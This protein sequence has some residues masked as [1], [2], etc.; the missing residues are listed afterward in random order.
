MRKRTGRYL[1]GCLLCWLLLF[2]L[3]WHLRAQVTIQNPDLLGQRLDRIEISGNRITEEE[4]ILREM[5]SR[6]GRIVTAEMLQ[7]DRLRVTSLD[8][9]SRVEFKLI[10]QDGEIVLQVIVTEEWYIF[11]T[12]FWDLTTDE[13]PKIIYGF[14]YVQKNLRGRAETLRVRLWGGADRGFKF[15]HRN[16]WVKGTPNFT[17]S[18]N[19]YQITRKSENLELKDQHLEARHTGIRLTFGRRW[20]REIST[21]IGSHFRIVS[22]GDPRQLA[23]DGNLD[24]ILEITASA[25]YDNRDLQ[26]FPKKGAYLY[27]W[28]T[29]GWL[30][31]SPL[32]YERFIFDVRRYF[33]CCA[34]FSICSRMTWMPA[35]GA[36]PPYDWIVVTNTEPI[37][38]AR[39][40]DEGKSFFMTSLEMRFELFKLH[41]FTW[42]GAPV[43]KQ[44]VRNLRYGL[45][46]ECFV[47]SGDAY[48]ARY[49]V[50]IGSLM[51]G[52]GV[53]LL[54]RLPY[55]DVL[56]LESSWNP[57][58]S[59]RNV[60]FSW[61]IGVA[62]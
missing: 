46:I 47:E 49:D 43:L 51:W 29:H 11:P 61:K 7:L 10:R 22:A 14:R 15:T 8:I 24:R 12:P 56:R 52:Y 23:T 13:P 62:F 48:N 60:N 59:W 33:S 39:L 50:S 17:R 57:R 19:L 20:T 4:I 26:Q 45:G 34:A 21:S 55:I 18:L 5:K 32:Q 40:S 27:A 3:P 54:V 42:Y 58:Y 25:A 38:S 28:F 31:D 2:L 16:P 1:R 36:V 41:Y 44:Y 53:G 35:W 6:P 9:F 37:R 30:T